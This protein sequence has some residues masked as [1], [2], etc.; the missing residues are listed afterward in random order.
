M[1]NLDGETS[2]PA[3]AGVYGKNTGQGGVAVAGV[4]AS[5][6]GVRAV[7]TSGN[8]LSAFSDSGVG[9][10]AK[11]NGQPGV[12]GTSESS[13]GVR[14][15]STSGNGLSAFSDSGVG[16]YAKANGQPGVV[17]TSESSDGVRAVSTSGNGLSAFSTTGAGLF[18]QGT[19]NAAYFKG[20]VVVTGDIQ[21]VE[22]AGDLAE[23]FDLDD[24]ALAEPGTVMVFSDSCGLRPATEPYDCRVAGVVTGG[25][26][27][28]PGL[29]L[30]RHSG[31]PRQDRGTVALVGKVYCKVDA[32]PSPIRVGDLLTTSSTE[33]HAQKAVSRQEAFGAVLGKAM[34]SL[35]SGQGLIPI[36]VALQ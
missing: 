16:A 27:Y 30:D 12:V 35:T 26:R 21:L 4:S 34:G 3:L 5:G 1:A 20:T 28:R 33:G 11:A 9:A 18:A 15:V 10:Y 7:S 8:G 22:G 25:G 14:A 32:D 13:D 6:D 31:I 29:V 17:G 19:P 36:L 23:D 24:Q 2:D